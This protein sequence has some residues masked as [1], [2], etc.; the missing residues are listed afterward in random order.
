M[1]RSFA[2]AVPLIAALALYACAGAGARKFPVPSCTWV[3]TAAVSAAVGEPVRALPERWRTFHAPVLTCYYAERTPHVQLGNL[4]L[5]SIQFAELQFYHVVKGEQPVRGIGVCVNRSTCPQP[6][7]PAWLFSATNQVT[8]ARAPYVFTFISE[9]RLFVQDGINAI[10]V[11]VQ[12]PS[13]PLRV[14]NVTARLK[15][16]ARSLMQRFYWE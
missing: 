9:E 15:S 14:K 5:V 16:L 10:A 1:R 8:R 6:G 13:G 12:N 7:R 2:I 3:S 4:P 11:G